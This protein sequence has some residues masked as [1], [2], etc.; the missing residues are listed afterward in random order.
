MAFCWRQAKFYLDNRAATLDY[1]D[2]TIP[3]PSQHSLYLTS[4]R[5]DDVL[6]IRNWLYRTALR[7]RLLGCF[8]ARE[9]RGLVIEFDNVADLMLFEQHWRVEA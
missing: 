3:I 2:A 5:I 1:C 8:A 6:Q 9:F 4:E 7:Y